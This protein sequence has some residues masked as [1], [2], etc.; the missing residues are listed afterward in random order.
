MSSTITWR[1]SLHSF[2]TAC[3]RLW[4]LKVFGSSERKKKNRKL[5]LMEWFICITQPPQTHYNQQSIK[6]T[7]DTLAKQNIVVFKSIMNDKSKASLKV[8]L[9]CHK[10]KCT[11]RQVTTHLPT[12]VTMNFQ[13]LQFELHRV[14]VGVRLLLQQLELGSVHLRQADALG[15]HLQ[16]A[17]ALNTRRKTITLYTY[18]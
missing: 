7:S 17:L 4:Y 1:I 15:L 10:H 18:S 5:E 12:L 2:V 14:C 11:Q 3:N 6:T 9:L 8:P 16:P 13:V